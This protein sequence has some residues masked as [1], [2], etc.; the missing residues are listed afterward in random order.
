[1]AWSFAAGQY[2]LPALTQMMRSG[3]QSEDLLQIGL[4]A[5]VFGRAVDG[6]PLS[7]GRDIVSEDR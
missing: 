7:G 6:N 4:V 2:S 1:M 3:A 5:E